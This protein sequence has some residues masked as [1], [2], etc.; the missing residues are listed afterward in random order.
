MSST[1]FILYVA[2]SI[3]CGG[4][5]KNS[6]WFMEIEKLI[7]VLLHSSRSPGDEV[8]IKS[9]GG[10]EAWRNNIQI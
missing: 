3:N 8:T 7:W 9:P 6:I 4:I 2:A 1:F 10:K 5:K